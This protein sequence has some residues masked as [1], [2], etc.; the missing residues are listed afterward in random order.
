[1]SPGTR[2]RE[3]EPGTKERCS[4]ALLVQFTAVKRKKL[5]LF[6]SFRALKFQSVLLYQIV[7][8]QILGK[9]TKFGGFSE[10]HIKIKRVRV[11]SPCGR[12]LFF[13]SPP[14]PAPRSPV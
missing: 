10:L 5:R 14:P 2:G 8:R 7:R 12:S 4:F 11:E 9:V 6:R 3:T 13:P 1:M